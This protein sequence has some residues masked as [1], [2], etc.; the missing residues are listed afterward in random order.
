MQEEIAL[1]KR[2]KN[3][4]EEDCGGDGGCAHQWQLNGPLL[5]IYSC[6]DIFIHLMLLKL[7]K[8]IYDS[9]TISQRACT[10]VTRSGST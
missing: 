2:V 5:L 9:Y 3:Q 1:R 6:C 4:R 8:D 10:F 7:L